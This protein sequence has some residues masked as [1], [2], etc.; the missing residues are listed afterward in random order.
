VITALKMIVRKK[1]DFYSS[2]ATGIIAGYFEESHVKTKN[3]Y[4]ELSDREKHVL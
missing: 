3:H 1:L 4:G 2:R